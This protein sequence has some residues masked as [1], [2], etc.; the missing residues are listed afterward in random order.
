MTLDRELYDILCYADKCQYDNEK[1]ISS[2]LSWI[3]V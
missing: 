1:M 3:Q 2:R